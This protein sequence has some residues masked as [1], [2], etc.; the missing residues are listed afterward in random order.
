MQ[1]F[2]YTN[3][4]ANLCLSL[5]HRLN[6]ISREVIS[7][8]S[9][10]DTNCSCD[11]SMKVGT[12]TRRNST[13]QSKSSVKLARLFLWHYA[14]NETILSL[15]R[16]VQGKICLPF[17]QNK[18]NFRLPWC[19]NVYFNTPRSANVWSY[20]K[21]TIITNLTACGKLCLGN[22]TSCKMLLKSLFQTNASETR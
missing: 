12:M 10:A 22:I 18:F 8:V 19:N 6:N 4:A 17:V 13:V 14:V 3:N 7:N 9:C 21:Q 16:E 1:I 20:N 5:S 11:W 2:L 15:S